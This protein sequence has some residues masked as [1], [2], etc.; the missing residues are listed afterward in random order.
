MRIVDIERGRDREVFEVELRGGM[1][2]LMVFATIT[3]GCMLLV[4]IRALTDRSIAEP[5]IALGFFVVCTVW[6]WLMLRWLGWQDL[7]VTVEPTRLTVVSLRSNRATAVD[8]A[9]GTTLGVAGRD[10][11]Q[12]VRLE[13]GA[14]TKKFTEYQVVTSMH[15]TVVRKVERREHAQE[16]CDH[17]ERS[18]R[19]LA[20]SA[21]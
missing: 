18:L 20:P 10:R 8:L 11:T 14:T 3:A 17:I 6:V 4:F 7:E 16:V 1:W 15:Q 2:M 5:S 13:H 9:P 12:K 19:R 21:S